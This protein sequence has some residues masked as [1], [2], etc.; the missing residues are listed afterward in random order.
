MSDEERFT[1]PR[2]SESIYQGDVTEIAVGVNPDDGLLMQIAPA[3]LNLDI[4]PPL[5]EDTL[6]CMADTRSFVILSQDGSV[7]L[8]FQPSDVC[9]LPNGDYVVSEAKYLERLRERYG[10]HPPNGNIAGSLSSLWVMTDSFGESMAI[11]VSPIRP[12]CEHYFRMQTDL[13]ADRERRHL[14]RACR[15]QLSA[16]GEYTSV[17]D[18]AVYACDLRSPRHLESEALLDDFDRKLIEQAREKEAR[19][20][21]DIDAELEKDSLGIFGGE[22]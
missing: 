12:Q 6:I 19:G 18:G 7:F 11:R 14:T 3:A 17:G 22:P 1:G 16:T 8:Q 10:D 9:R 4:A 13:S 20:S 15:A 5:R 21:F 2:A